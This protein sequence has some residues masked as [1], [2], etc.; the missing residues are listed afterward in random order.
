MTKH[1]KVLQTNFKIWNAKKGSIENEI[2]HI[3]PELEQLNRKIDARA[4]EILSRE[5]RINDIV[6]RIY[7]NLVHMLG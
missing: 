4:Q 7:K 5:K 1:R 2:G 6:D 3:Q